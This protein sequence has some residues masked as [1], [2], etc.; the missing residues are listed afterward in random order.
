VRGSV[1]KKREKVGRC[2][3]SYCLLGRAKNGE[4]RGNELKKSG[5][6]REGK[7]EGEGRGRD[8]TLFFK[9]RKRKEKVKKSRKSRG[10]QS[11]GKESEEGI[12]LAF[13]AFRFTRGRT[14]GKEKGK[15]SKPT[16]E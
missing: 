7:K 8:A 13:L 6:G 15:Q 5:P 14:M 10:G 3:L 4:K 9:K 2:V 1:G 12:P 11:E 16:G